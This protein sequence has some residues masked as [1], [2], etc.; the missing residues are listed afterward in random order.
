M[1]FATRAS[2]RVKTGRA[3]IALAVSLCLLN[4]VMASAQSAFDDPG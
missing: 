4:P 1:I 2:S 3:I